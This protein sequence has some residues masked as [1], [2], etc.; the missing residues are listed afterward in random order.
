MLCDTVEFLRTYPD[1][2]VAYVAISLFLGP[3]LLGAALLVIV[4]SAIKQTYKHQFYIALGLAIVGSSVFGFLVW[5]FRV[6]PD[7]YSPACL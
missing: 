3:G 4:E 2:L 7:W 6:Q 5:L 1:F